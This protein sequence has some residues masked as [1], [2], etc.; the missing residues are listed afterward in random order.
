MAKG[1]YIYEPAVDIRPVRSGGA[2][3]GFGLCESG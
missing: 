3:F 2:D 1:A